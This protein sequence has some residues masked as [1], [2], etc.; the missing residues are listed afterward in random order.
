[1]NPPTT[2]RFLFDLLQKKNPQTEHDF[3]LEKQ[4]L[5]HEAKLAVQDDFVKKEKDREIQN[6]ITR[7][8]EIGECRIKKMKLRDTL[9]QQL[10]SEATQ[11]CVAVS[12]GT[13]YSQLV[14]KLLVQAL[15]KIEET[16]V[17]VYCRTKDVPVVTKVLSN[18]V[19]E[20]VDIMQR[21]SGVT[22]QPIVTMN[23]DRTK[24]LSDSVGGGMILSALHGHITCDNTLQSRLLLVYEEL[25]PAIRSILFPD[26]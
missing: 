14:Q 9:L 13:N 22:L 17:E 15:I 18:A 11:K 23:T 8:N 12:N 4:T 2:S 7:S 24:D 16:T 20:Y 5:V 25:L 21:E 1:L 10:I 26:E 6:R 19:Q 3:N